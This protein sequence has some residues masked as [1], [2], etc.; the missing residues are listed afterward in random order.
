VC[1]C[2]E[3]L[4]W[5]A[6]GEVWLTTVLMMEFYGLSMFTQCWRTSEDIKSAGSLRSP[7]MI[8][9]STCIMFVA[10][11]S[12][13]TCIYLYNVCCALLC[14][15][16]DLKSSFGRYRFR[17]TVSDLGRHAE[18]TNM[19][20]KAEESATCWKNEQGDKTSWLEALIC[21]SDI[22]GRLSNHSIE[23]F[24]LLSQADV[25]ICRLQ[26]SR[27]VF[28]CTV[29]FSASNNYAKYV[30]MAARWQTAVRTERYWSLPDLYAHLHWAAALP[31]VRCST[32]TFPMGS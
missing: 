4:R 32:F 7:L 19:G 25:K 28:Y 21:R 5:G 11:S 13:D 9:A 10:L 31:L 23:T 15:W 27:F 1:V 2:V 12:H 20:R 29:S 14:Q 30:P 8:P 18:P 24:S 26:L 16:T 6:F 22:C 17:I 3:N